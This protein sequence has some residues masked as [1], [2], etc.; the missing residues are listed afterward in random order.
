MERGVRQGREVGWKLIY[1]QKKHC[2]GV[3][4]SHYVRTK[5]AKATDRCCCDH[6]LQLGSNSTAVAVVVCSVFPMGPLIP[7]PRACH[8]LQLLFSYTH[9]HTHTMYIS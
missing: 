9:T 3:Q 5:L 6:F 7:S 8:A 1:V 4:S 2:S